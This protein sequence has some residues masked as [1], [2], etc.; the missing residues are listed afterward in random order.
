MQISDEMLIDGMA[1]NTPAATTA[2]HDQSPLESRVLF[3]GPYDDGRASITSP[4]KTPRSAIAP[5]PSPSAT[6]GRPKKLK[7]LE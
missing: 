7:E 5:G 2:G 6:F 4:T 1:T 3:N